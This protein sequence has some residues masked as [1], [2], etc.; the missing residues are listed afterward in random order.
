MP[1]QTTT[2]RRSNTTGA[3]QIATVHFKTK[4]GV[5]GNPMQFGVFNEVILNAVGQVVPSAARLTSTAILSATTESSWANQIQIYPN[6][7]ADGKFFISTQNI[8][9]QQIIVVDLV[10]KV[11]QILD[12]TSIVQ[13]TSSTEIP[14]SISASG[15]YFLKIQTERGVVVRKIVRL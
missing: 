14:L 8:D 4:K 10:G 7:T 6:P 13:H 9:I 3:G 12:K 15:T 1:R 11:I 5:R 2:V